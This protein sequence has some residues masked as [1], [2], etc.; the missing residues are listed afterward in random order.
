MLRPPACHRLL[1]GPCPPLVPPHTRS[2]PRRPRVE[3]TGLTKHLRGRY[4]CARVAHHGAARASQTRAAPHR[5]CPRPPQTRRPHLCSG[6]P[7]RRL[8]PHSPARPRGSAGTPR[9][10]SRRRPPP[11]SAGTGASPGPAPSA[12]RPGC[13][14]LASKPKASKSNTVRTPQR[15]CATTAKR[16]PSGTWQS[17]LVSLAPALT[18]APRLTPSCASGTQVLRSLLPKGVDRGTERLR[19]ANYKAGGP[20]HCPRVSRSRLP[21]QPEAPFPM[22]CAISRGPN[23]TGPGGR[24]PS[25]ATEGALTPHPGSRRELPP[26]C[27][28][29]EA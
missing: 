16:P 26:P 29:P 15:Q 7:A 9:C 19:P 24:A 21:V 13:L 8:C 1:P 5:T 23:H 18:R 10:S 4:L 25:L 20:H 22:V 2:R 11:S 6:P 27:H 28:R 12:S 3:G 14:S 17:A